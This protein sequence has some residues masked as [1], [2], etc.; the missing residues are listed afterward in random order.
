MDAQRGGGEMAAELCIS[1]DRGR[2]QSRNTYS[3]YKQ[4]EWRFGGHQA[5]QAHDQWQLAEYCRDGPSRWKAQET[6][7]SC[8]DLA[9]VQRLDGGE[10]DFCPF[11]LG[12]FYTPYAVVWVSVEISHSCKTHVK[13]QRRSIKEKPML[14]HGCNNACPLKWLYWRYVVLNKIHL[15]NGFTCFFL[16][17]WNYF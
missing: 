7:L 9:S 16:L 6:G 3:Q 4:L 1:A 13:F 11:S 17:F 14:I 2:T 12:S 10:P 5:N 15:R 8:R